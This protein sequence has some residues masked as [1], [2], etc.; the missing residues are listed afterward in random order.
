MRRRARRDEV[1]K[2]GWLIVFIRV[3][4]L[5]LAVYPTAIRNVV[6]NELLA[7]LVGQSIT[8][9]IACVFLLLIPAQ[10]DAMQSLV[11]DTAV[12]PNPTRA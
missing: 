4:R 5:V 3:R 6:Y 1:F 9:K 2:D 7:T 8:T 11:R 10:T 12:S